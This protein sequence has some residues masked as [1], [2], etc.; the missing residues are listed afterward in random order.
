MEGVYRREVTYS[1]PS[2]GGGRSPIR[3]TKI[4]E[5]SNGVGSNK[6]TTTIDFEGQSY[7]SRTVIEKELPEPY[8]S[9]KKRS[10]VTTYAQ[11]EEPV[12]TY[13]YTR[14]DP[15]SGAKTVTEV[16]YNSPSRQR[17]ETTQVSYEGEPYSGT[18][19]T[20]TTR[21]E[22]SPG[23]RVV[24]TK[25]VQGEGPYKS[26]VTR[27]EVRDEV[28]ERVHTRTIRENGKEYT[29]TTRYVRPSEPVEEIEERVYESPSRT[30]T[31]KTVKTSSGKEQTTTTSYQR[32]APVEAVI[33]E[34]EEGFGPN[35]TYRRTVTENGKE[36]TT[37]TRYV[38][39][40]PPLEE[41]IVEKAYDP[42]SR[43]YTTTS[44][45][46]KGDEKVVSVTT[47]NQFGEEKVVTT[48]YRN[49]APRWED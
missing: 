11:E 26:S 31:T 44:R 9:S 7:S 1:S 16:E 32:P 41:E 48:T 12:K 24:T 37:T 22:Q 18:K 17:R 14:T 28:P 27:T 47:R 45:V 30:Y 40:A 38:Q 2:R 21:T 39:P 4:V 3:T 49:V 35:K 15:Y 5:S 23:R 19:K 42:A 13:T 43:T 8:S 10:V 34:V 6:K 29:T 36:Y 25:T 46:S 33:E 20:V